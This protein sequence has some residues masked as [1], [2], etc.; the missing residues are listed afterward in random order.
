M[1]TATLLNL[2]IIYFKRLAWLTKP[3]IEGTTSASSRYLIAR[4]AFLSISDKKAAP[5]NAA[6]LIKIG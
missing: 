2:R 4:E 3:Q 1:Q 6:F 5:F